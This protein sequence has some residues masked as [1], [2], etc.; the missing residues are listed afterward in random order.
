[1]Q[2]TSSPSLIAPAPRFRTPW[3]ERGRDMSSLL[4]AGDRV[5]TAGGQGPLC[6]IIHISQKKAWIRHLEK[7]D[8]SIVP[9]HELRL[10]GA[11]EGGPTLM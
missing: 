11:M 10:V 7:G 1:M 3:V 6:E 4:A 2:H 8:Q 9:L 5:A